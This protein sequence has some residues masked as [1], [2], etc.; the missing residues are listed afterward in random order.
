MYSIKYRAFG[1]SSWKILW[2]P[3]DEKHAGIDPVL[4]ET[5]GKAGQ[6]TID[7]PDTNEALSDIEPY[8]T[9]VRVDRDGEPYW[10]GRVITAEAD[11]FN[12]TAATCEGELSYL[13]DSILPP[14]SFTGT[15]A[16]Y[17][18]LLIAAHN[19]SVE[20]EK[21]F[22]V[23]TVEV[24]A[25][26]NIT[27]SSTQYP[28]VYDELESKL[29]D[30]FGGYLR[31]RH[32]NGTTYIDYLYTFGA[33][34]TQALRPDQNMI[35]YSRKKGGGTFYTRLYPL[36]GQDEDG[37]VVTIKSVNQGIEYIENSTLVQKY[38]VISAVK[39]WGTITT[40]STL[41][42]R[43]REDLAA[44]ELPDS[45]ELS[46]VDL[47]NINAEIDAFEIGKRTRVISPYHGISAYYFLTRKISHL[48]APEDDS[49]YCGEIPK[50]YTHDTIQQQRQ[51]QR[52]AEYD[53]DELDLTLDQIDTDIG[54][55]NTNIGNINTN[56]G[57]LQTGLQSTTQTAN[58]ANTNATNAGTAAAAAQQT[59]NAA[60]ANAAEA[61]SRANAALGAITPHEVVTVSDFDPTETYAT[62]T[63]VIVIEDGV[64]SS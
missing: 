55:I 1:G 18:A 38:G 29:L 7:L 48:D 41:L 31:T 24:T 25:D 8:K 3:L 6:L 52:A 9:V 53:F 54:N 11:F 15:L 57:N 39:T 59:A 22:T 56:I 37:N 51:T 2:Q 10:Y 64:T 63:I 17:F 19:A 46:A 21:Q 47:H 13:N 40:P 14:Y 61:L 44:Q 58:T 43:G 30:V 12:Q 27:R 20:A 50:T 35:D 4:T 23:G 5:V 33:D 34:N 32:E 45:F 26:S 49:I 16:D 62:G 60:A 42:T 36:G 28:S